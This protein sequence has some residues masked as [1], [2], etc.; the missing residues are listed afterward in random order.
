VPAPSPVSASSAPCTQGSSE[1][2]K[3]SILPHSGSATTAF[4]SV[5]NQLQAQINEQRQQL[6]Q[7][8]KL[9]EQLLLQSPQSTAEKAAKSSQPSKALG[10]NGT[11]L[12]S[13]EEIMKELEEKAEAKAQEDKEKLKRK[14]HSEEKQAAKKRK[15]RED[16]EQTQPKS[17][18]QKSQQYTKQ[19]SKA[20]SSAKPSSSPSSQQPVLHDV[21]STVFPAPVAAPLTVTIESSSMEIDEPSVSSSR[22]RRTAASNNPFIH[23]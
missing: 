3:T 20:K 13:R 6:Q 11:I 4:D 9:I 15:T 10:I 19:R 8:K 16:D 21:S 5:V 2:P 22:P 1:S 12:L 23:L 7:Q 14:Q 17:K 18:K